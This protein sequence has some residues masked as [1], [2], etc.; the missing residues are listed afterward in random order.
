MAVR[1]RLSRIGKKHLPIYRIVAMDSKKSRDGEAL[2]IIGTYDGVKASIICFNKDLFE[3]WVKNGAEI[4]DSVKKVVK[5]AKKQGFFKA[6]EELQ[7]NLQ[8]A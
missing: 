3:K 4:N 5:I 7:T 8:N 6:K 1:L 2:D